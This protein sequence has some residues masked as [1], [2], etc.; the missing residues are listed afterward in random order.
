MGAAVLASR[1]PWVR[2]ARVLRQCTRSALAFSQRYF[3]HHPRVTSVPASAHR[4]GAQL[5]SPLGAQTPGFC[6]D[7][8]PFSGTHRGV[9]TPLGTAQWVWLLWPRFPG[10]PC[11][12]Q[13]VRAHSLCSLRALLESESGPALVLPYHWQNGTWL[14]GVVVV[15]RGPYL[16]W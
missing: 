3:C 15:H 8:R 1:I 14:R 16:Q 12:F 6:V 7:P 2:A 4:R 5:H 9:Y 11:Q 10:R 13:T